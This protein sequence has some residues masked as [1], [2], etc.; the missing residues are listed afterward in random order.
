MKGICFHIF[1]QWNCKIPEFPERDEM[2][3]QSAQGAAIFFRLIRWSIGLQE[4]VTQRQTADR[5]WFLRLKTFV[6]FF[7]ACAERTGFL[8]EFQ[9]WKGRKKC[10]GANWEKFK[11][12]TKSSWKETEFSHFPQHTICSSKHTAGREKI[13]P[14]LFNKHW[15]P[16][17]REG[18]PNFWNTPCSQTTEPHKNN[19][20][21]P[22]MQLSIRHA[23]GSC[24][25][26]VGQ[27]FVS[28]M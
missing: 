27:V 13:T 15:A 10:V 16:C 9:W 14:I 22:D 23:C 2:R 20:E 26:G 18:H 1:L 4:P 8:W 28:Q 7:A 21:S 17:L 5:A 25:P 6:F 3:N 24:V 11:Y 19:T 12:K